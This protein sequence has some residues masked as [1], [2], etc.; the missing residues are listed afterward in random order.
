MANGVP[1]PPRRPLPP[2]R[3]QVLHAKLSDKEL[4]HPVKVPPFDVWR[5][6]Q[7]TVIE[8]RPIVTCGNILG[9]A[10]RQRYKKYIVPIFSSFL[11]KG[12]SPE[13]CRA[14]G[15]SR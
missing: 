9:H 6:W 13:E 2:R 8:R 10:E 5:K 3:R 12:Y 1:G 14:R 7:R 15:P 11:Q 4:A